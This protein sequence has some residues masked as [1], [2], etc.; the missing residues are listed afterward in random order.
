MG[1]MMG[2]MGGAAQEPPK[3]N[4]QPD[5]GDKKKSPGDGAVDAD[6]E[7]VDDK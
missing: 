4:P 2:G 1:D 7:V 6:F 3:S 5:G